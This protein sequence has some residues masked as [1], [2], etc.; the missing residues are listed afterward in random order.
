MLVIALSLAIPYST[1]THCQINLCCIN[2]HPGTWPT[3]AP[4]LTFFKVKLSIINCSFDC[5]GVTVR[6]TML[7]VPRV[8]PLVIGRYLGACDD[9]IGVVCDLVSV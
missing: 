1:A 5:S 4:L 8:A 2:G 9:C 7:V 6:W 3:T